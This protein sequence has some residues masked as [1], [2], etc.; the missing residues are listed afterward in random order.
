MYVRSFPGDRVMWVYTFL[1]ALLNPFEHINAVPWLQGDNRFLVSAS[2]HL[3]SAV[4]QIT[5]YL[6]GSIYDIHAQDCYIKHRLNRFFDLTLI[7]SR[8]NF[9]SELVQITALKARLLCNK[10]ATQ[11]I[12]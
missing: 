10:G 1:P 2:P 5:R 8:V 9:E 4:P 12:V 11:D 7:G 6:W 3:A